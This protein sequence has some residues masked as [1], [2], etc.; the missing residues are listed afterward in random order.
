MPDTASITSRTSGRITAAPPHHEVVVLG[1]GFGGL[2][3]AIRL[4]QA[5]KRDVVVLEREHE[6]GGTWRDNTY[7]GCQ[8]DVASNI[9]S[10]SFAPNPS[11]SRTYALQAEIFA[12]LRECAD[13]FGVRPL[14]RFGTELLQA[15]WL[16]D[17][18]RWQLRT[19][20]GLLTADSL[21]LGQGGLSAPSVPELPGL[22]R[23][24]GTV[25]HSA[26]WNH[27]Y[28]LGGKRVGVVGTGASAIQI[29]PAIQPKVEKL[30]LF[31]R[32]PAW[33]VPRHDYPFNRLER[34]LF[35]YLPFTQKL[36]R[37]RLYWSRELVVLGMTHPKWMQLGER[38]ALNHLREQ[39]KDRALRKKLKPSYAL[40]CK[41]I[42]LSN[43]YYPALAQDNAEVVTGAIREV[44]AHG[45]VA[46]DGTEH[47]LD[48]LVLCTGF[49]VTDHPITQIV[50]GRDGRSLAEHW[51]QGAQSHLG[52]TV[53]GFPNLYLL[54]GPNTGLGHNSIVY[55]L[56]AQFEYILGAL[57]EL[58]ARGGGA[59]DVSE[60]AVQAFGDEMQARLQGTVWSSGCASWYLDKNGRNTT[61]WPSFSFEFRKRTQH[62]DAHA[63]IHEPR[64]AALSTRLQA[65]S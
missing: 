57:R 1:S 26:A 47:A 18:Q 4:L 37:A 63:Y 16:P 61:V 14:I 15:N 60:Q 27:D 17:Q 28:D 24:E 30:T 21:I 3:M 39:V 32:T 54:T 46:E 13:R 29:V 31:Q 48:A 34:F 51:V 11:W 58:E 33:I 5:G 22:D 2:G 7:P 62:F 42:L 53:H 55:M 9:Y 8:C 52:T 35:R 40:G 25:F 50:Y 49:Q 36:D 20:Q 56:E 59:F 6:V 19:S 43:E 10:Y 12:Y 65:A 45:V 44:T 41:R 23:F 38:I 64:S